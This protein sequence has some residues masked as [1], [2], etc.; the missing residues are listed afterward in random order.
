MLIQEAGYEAMQYSILV[1]MKCSEDLKP[2][3]CALYSP[4]CMEGYHKYL[5]PCRFLCERARSGCESV[6]R[7]NNYVVSKENIL[8]KSN[9]AP[10]NCSALLGSPKSIVIVHCHS[11]SDNTI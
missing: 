5:P 6:M 1:D 10:T 3:L 2:F 4:V 11:D 7:R 8:G 9:S